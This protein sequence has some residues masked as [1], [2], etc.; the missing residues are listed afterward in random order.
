MLR[1]LRLLRLLRSLPAKKARLR[2]ALIVQRGSQGSQ[3]I[4]AHVLVLEQGFQYLEL[5]ILV[6]G[7]AQLLQGFWRCLIVLQGLLLLQGH[8][9]G[10]EG[11]L[12]RSRHASWQC[13]ARPGEHVGLRVQHRAIQPVQVL[14]CPHLLE[15][16]PCTIQGS[17]ALAACMQPDRVPMWL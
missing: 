2:L 3:A 12:W 13:L 16:R 17:S 9:V 1:L 4:H 8:G 14:P 5:R 10:Q 6:D 11:L 7:H 15:V